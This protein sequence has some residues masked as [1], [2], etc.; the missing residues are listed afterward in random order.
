M[1]LRAVITREAEK[2]PASSEMTGWVKPDATDKPGNG[3]GADTEARWR[4]DLCGE[5]HHGA[6]EPPASGFCGKAS[7]IE[8][9]EIIL[10]LELLTTEMVHSV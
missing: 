8:A 5:R 3:R 7:S 1:H 10:K 9:D 6:V 4:I 2:R